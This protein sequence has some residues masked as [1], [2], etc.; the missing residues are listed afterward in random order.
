MMRLPHTLAVL[1]GLSLSTSLL[2][3]GRESA[4][5]QNYNWEAP[6]TWTETAPP[7]PPYPDG[8][9]WLPFTIHGQTDNQHFIDSQS[10]TVGSDGVVRYVLRVKSALGAETLTYE[11]LHCAGNNHKRYAIGRPDTQTWMTSQTADWRRINV[12]QYLIRTLSE[13][14]FC[15]DHVSV[16]HAEEAI[17]RIK[18]APR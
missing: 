12:S 10:L 5:N 3:G 16:R 15:P 18:A 2:A 11:G 13:E 1:L 8:Q 17:K 6:T 4:Y 9:H 14:L 7:L